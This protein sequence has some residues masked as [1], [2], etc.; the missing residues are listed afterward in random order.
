MNSKNSFSLSDGLPRLPVGVFDPAV[1]A[2]R[3][4]KILKPWW[5]EHALRDRGLRAEWLLGAIIAAR[6]HKPDL[7]EAYVLAC[8]RDGV[9]E[10]YV[11]QAEEIIQHNKPKSYTGR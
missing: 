11:R 8:L 9:G 5:E 1:D 6:K 7:P 10:A 4:P 3:L 2:E